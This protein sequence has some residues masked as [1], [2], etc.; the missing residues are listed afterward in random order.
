VQLQ[1]WPL[2]GRL[3]LHVEVA[4]EGLCAHQLSQ[5]SQIGG[6]LVLQV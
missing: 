5:I 2:A 1:S 3:P 6:K 4:V